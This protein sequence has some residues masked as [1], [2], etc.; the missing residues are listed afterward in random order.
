MGKESEFL[1]VATLGK[2]GNW[3]MSFFCL[4]PSQKGSKLALRGLTFVFPCRKG[5]GISLVFV[6][7]FPAFRQTGNA[8]STLASAVS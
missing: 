4:S 6:N 5:G 2:A 7:Q 8:E 3:Q 1:G